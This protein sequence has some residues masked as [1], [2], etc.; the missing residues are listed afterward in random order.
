[1]RAV[2]IKYLFMGIISFSLMI[3]ID[4][5]HLNVSLLTEGL[6]NFENKYLIRMLVYFLSTTFIFLALFDNKKNKSSRIVNNLNLIQR[7]LFVSAFVTSIFLV[8]KVSSPFVVFAV[9][10]IS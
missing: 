7:L 4:T 6:P 8:I 3:L 2:N 1:M 9:I 10:T 5:F